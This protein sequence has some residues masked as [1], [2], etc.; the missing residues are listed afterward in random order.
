MARIEIIGLPG[1]GK[2][3]L[4]ERLQAARPLPPLLAPINPGGISTIRHA[5]RLAGK[6]FLSKG[7]SSLLARKDATWL[8][9]KLGY[10]LAGLKMR[11]GGGILVDSGVLMPLVSY[12]SEYANRDAVA[13]D[14]LGL[15]PILPRPDGMIYL[16]SGVDVS[17]ERYL[18]RQES[19]GRRPGTEI[20]A[21][22]FAIAQEI[23]EGIWNFF[24]EDRKFL[25]AG[26]GVVTDAALDEIAC[27][28]R[29]WFNMENN[30]HEIS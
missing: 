15:L 6:L 5:L 30:G 7:F 14:V 20:D 3:T 10:R 9:S 19:M 21:R 27:Q 17:L 25:V 28:M 11:G 16:N 26:E 24:P 22:R 2:T 13:S 18:R 12:A 4:L 29:T 23:C 8:F 1:S